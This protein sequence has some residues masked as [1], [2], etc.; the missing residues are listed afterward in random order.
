MSRADNNFLNEIDR[1][2]RKRQMLVNR[3]DKTYAGPIGFLIIGIH[4]FND[5]FFTVIKVKELKCLKQET[6]CVAVIYILYIL[7]Q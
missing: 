6:R 2:L 3:V 4:K 5:T 1:I 7:T